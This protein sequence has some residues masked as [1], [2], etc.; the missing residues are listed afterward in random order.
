MLALDENSQEAGGKDAVAT[1][2]AAAERLA[3][4]ARRLF[5]L[6]CVRA[7]IVRLITPGKAQ[8]AI[9]RASADELGFALLNVYMSLLHPTFPALAQLLLELPMEC[10][11]HQ[12]H[13]QGELEEVQPLVDCDVLLC[14]F[15]LFLPLVPSWE[16]ELLRRFVG[17]P[18]YR[19]FLWAHLVLDSRDFLLVTCPQPPLREVRH[20]RLD[21]KQLRRGAEDTTLVAEGG[22][23]DSQEALSVPLLAD[24][25]EVVAS[26]E[27]HA[28]VLP[29]GALQHTKKNVN[30]TKGR[31]Y[32]RIPQRCAS[33]APPGELLNH[34]FNGNQMYFL[35][36]EVEVSPENFEFDLKNGLR[37]LHALPYSGVF[38]TSFMFPGVHGDATVAA[39]SVA[40]AAATAEAS[41]KL[42]R[43][44]YVFAALRNDP[45]AAQK[46]QEITSGL[47]ES[48][49]DAAR[50]RISQLEAW[51]QMLMQH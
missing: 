5:A 47:L 50:G 4:Q 14:V 30:E 20:H 43:S 2:A 46:I 25:N 10:L 41:E 40:A 38:C 27:A 37:E 7:N 9:L 31:F 23:R 19:N 22:E 13:Q 6:F 39:A 33:L 15:L 34:H 35:T 21:T 44:A 1:A 8:M 11:Q 12:K 18:N 42:W 51:G 48:V 28:V 3:A 36:L 16:H 26:K 49:F 29:M 24:V 32:V 17:H 45:A